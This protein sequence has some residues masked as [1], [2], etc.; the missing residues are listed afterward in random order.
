MKLKTLFA[1]AIN[2]AFAKPWKDKTGETVNIS[3]MAAFSTK[4]T[5]PG[6]NKGSLRR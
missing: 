4:S 2:A 3:P 6:N 5:R 1:Q